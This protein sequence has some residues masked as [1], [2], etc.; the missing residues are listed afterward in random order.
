MDASIGQAAEAQASAFKDAVNIG[1][2]II[3]KL[4]GHAKGGGALSAVAATRSP[5][6]FIGVGEHIYD[7]ERFDVKSFVSKLLG[8]GD[9]AGLAEKVQEIN[10]DKQKAMI[11]NLEA[12]TFSLRDMY[13]QFQT[14]LQMGSVSQIMGMMPGLNADMFKGSDAES[15][16]RIKRFLT[17]IESMT[18][19]EL[20]SPDGKIFTMP[21]QEGRILRIARGSGCHPREVDMLLLQHKQFAAMVKTM[22]GKNG[23]FNKMGDLK[24]NANP[25]ALAQMQQQ[26]AKMIPPQM[27]RQLGGAG[28]LQNFIKQM[29]SNPDMAKMMG[30]MGKM[31]GK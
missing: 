21:K 23:L 29:G 14:I 25:K 3:T 18:D 7:L 20:D 5:I 31:F 16:A 11:K 10:T 26:M 1:S 15:G 28:G 24:N 13:E 30:D 12:G 2:V 27:M 9:L 19:D 22:G 6:M 4:D 17:I 8:M